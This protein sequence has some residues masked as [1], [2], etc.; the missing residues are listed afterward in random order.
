MRMDRQL[1]AVEQHFVAARYAD[2]GEVLDIGEIAELVGLV[3]DVQP[4]ELDPGKL[5]AKGEKAPK[6]KTAAPSPKRKKPEMKVPVGQKIW[7]SL[8]VAIRVYDFARRI[9]VLING[10]SN[11]P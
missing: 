5:L 1:H 10:A 9:W 3:L 7:D 11:P 8:R 6:R 2:G 4:A